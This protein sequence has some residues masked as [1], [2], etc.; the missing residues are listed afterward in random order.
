MKRRR[1]ATIMIDELDQDYYMPAALSKKMG[2]NR[3]TLYRLILKM[4]MR[5]GYKGAY[6]DLSHNLKLVNVKKFVAFLE[7]LDG[8]YLREAKQ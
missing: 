1:F 7:E 2:L 5:P 3:V 8:E 4:R 6:L